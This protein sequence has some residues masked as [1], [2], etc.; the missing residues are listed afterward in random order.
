MHDLIITMAN[1]GP[2]RAN[3][4]MQSVSLFI[5]FQRQKCHCDLQ[6]VRESEREREERERREATYGEKEA[7]IK[8]PQAL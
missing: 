6:K 1:S 4:G 7:A 5:Y 8:S 3:R 2:S